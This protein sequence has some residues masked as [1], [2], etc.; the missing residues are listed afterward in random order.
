MTSAMSVLLV[1][2]FSLGDFESGDIGKS[3]DG[4]G[5]G[6]IRMPDTLNSSMESVQE[7]GLA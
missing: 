4:E 6:V 5:I 3:V 2:V 7:D 1:H